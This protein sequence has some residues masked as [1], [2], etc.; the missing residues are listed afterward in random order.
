VTVVRDGGEPVAALVHDAGV[1]ADRELVES[2]AAAAR[3]AVSNALLQAGIRSQVEELDASRRRVVEAADGERRRLEHQLRE[4][5]ERRLAELEAILGEAQ[6]HAND[7]PAEML[8][9]AQARLAQARSDLREFARG[10]HPRV[11]S[12]DGLPAALRELADRTSVPTEVSVAEV[13]FP[14][15]VEVAAYFVCSEALANVAKYAAASSA[16]IDVTRRGGSVVVSV[17]DDGCGGVRIGAGSGLRGLVDRVEALGGR[18]TVTSAPG[19]GTQL[20]AEVPI[21]EATGPS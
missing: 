5:A 1:L 10:V 20:I 3:L 8:A 15:P 6:H 13:R 2:I 7:G 17:R 11:L 12:E 14:A 21:A 18:L 9:T 16:A 19:E 4:G